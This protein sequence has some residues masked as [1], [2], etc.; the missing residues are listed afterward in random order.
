MENAVMKALDPRGLFDTVQRAPLSPRLDTLE[1]KTVY[2]INSWPGETHGFTKV[3]EA[4]DAYL[5]EKYAGIRLEYR[6]RMRYSYDDPARRAEMKE[7]A[8]C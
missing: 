1:G 4:L 7:Q 6:T 8:D 3:E 5:R 2:I